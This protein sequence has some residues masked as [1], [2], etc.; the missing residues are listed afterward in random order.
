[1]CSLTNLL[2]SLEAKLAEGEE[3]DGSAERVV[4]ENIV[5]QTVIVFQ[6]NDDFLKHRVRN[7]PET[8]VAGTHYTEEGMARRLGEFRKANEAG[9]GES[10]IVDF[11]K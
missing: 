10:T 5:P 11:F 9:T 3:D 6:G 1:M 8:Q 7:L 4:D 2:H